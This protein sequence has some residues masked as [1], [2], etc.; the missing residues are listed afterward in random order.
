MDRFCSL[1]ERGKHEEAKAQLLKLR[2]VPNVDEEFNDL[3]AANEASKLVKHPWVTL[4]S[5]KYRP[6]LVFAIG[7]PVFQQLTDT[8]VITFYAPVL[9]KTMGF[10]SSASLMAAVITNLV[11]ALATFVSILTVDKVGRRK[12][13]LQGGCQML[14]MQTTGNHRRVEGFQIVVKSTAIFYTNNNDG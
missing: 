3:V 5:R 7:I 14:L 13:F 8:N 11:N 12:L 6:Q 4:L 1:V 10:G 2:G 9:F